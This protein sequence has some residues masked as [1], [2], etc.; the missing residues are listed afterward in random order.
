MGGNVMQTKYFENDD[1]RYVEIT[2]PGFWS[3]MVNVNQFID[4]T[5]G[6]W[7]PAEITWSSGGS[8][9]PHNDMSHTTNFAAAL[10]HAMAIK[11]E[12]DLDVGQPVTPHA[13]KYMT[14]DDNYLPPFAYA[15]LPSTGDTILIRRFADEYIKVNDSN[16]NDLNAELHVNKAQASAM[17]CGAM[18]GWD[19]NGAKPE[20]YCKKCGYGKPSCMCI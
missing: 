2:P 1:K 10:A 3:S 12:L 14:D 9:L 6:T 15:I 7:Q 18:F 19:K 5:D 11:A 13:K 20:I 4:I 8:N 17:L 16:P